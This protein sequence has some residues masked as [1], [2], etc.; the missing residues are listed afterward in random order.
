MD[1]KPKVIRDT[2]EKNG[3]MFSKTESINGTL[4]QTMKTGDYTL[5][6]YEH[7]LCIERK[8]S[9]T[10]IA[11]NLTTK[12]FENE[13]QRMQAFKH[14]YVVI[15]DTMDNFTT[16]PKNADLPPNVKKSIKVNGIFLLRKLFELQIKY[17]FTPLFVGKHGKM[18]V[19]S[20][21]KRIM[22]L[23]SPH[24]ETEEAIQPGP[25]NRDSRVPAPRL[26]RRYTIKD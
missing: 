15:E 20:I 24:G 18:V 7:I 6:G 14:K 8:R 25:D 22:E 17:G 26:G 2:R 21:F 16:F 19:L 9:V 10:E 11:T 13:M 3:W 1:H 23:E 4:I 12:R 5:E